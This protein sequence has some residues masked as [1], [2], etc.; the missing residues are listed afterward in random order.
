[1]DDAHWADTGSL[2]LLR[3]LARRVS[4]LRVLIVLT[5]REIELDEASPL[6]GVLFDLYRERLAT[7]LKLT[8]F[9]RQQTGEMLATILSPIGEID[10]DLVDAIYRET[11]GNPFFIE[12]VTKGLIEEASRLHSLLG[13]GETSEFETPSPCA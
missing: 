10:P 9:D 4:N 12:E 7:R 6:Q 2:F 5:Y 3:H 11:E 8:R 13:G 1:V